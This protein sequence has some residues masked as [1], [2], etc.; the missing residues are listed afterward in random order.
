[1]IDLV[2]QQLNT[3]TQVVT[4]SRKNH[5]SRQTHTRVEGQSAAASLRYR[6]G[7]QSPTPLKWE[8]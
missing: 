1:M 5:K 8:M 4:L 3:N 7:G 6:A 2:M